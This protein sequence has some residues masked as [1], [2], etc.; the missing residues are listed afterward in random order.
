MRWHFFDNAIEACQSQAD[1][2]ISVLLTKYS[3]NNYSLI[4][5]NTISQPVN[6]AQVL[7]PRVTSKQNHDGLGLDN[8]NEIVNSDPYLSLEIEQSVSEIS[9]ELVIQKG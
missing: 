6:L 5:Q 1:G 4:V 9:F 3:G 2:Q 7:K 8:V